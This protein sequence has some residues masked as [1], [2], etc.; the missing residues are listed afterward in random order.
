MVDLCGWSA[1]VS[2]KPLRYEKDMRFRS[3]IC[4]FEAPLSADS[5]FRFENEFMIVVAIIE[6]VNLYD[7]K[8]VSGV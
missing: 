8:E 2:P 4:R 3:V 7:I 5:I 6:A 1:S